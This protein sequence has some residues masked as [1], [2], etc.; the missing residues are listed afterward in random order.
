MTIDVLDN[1]LIL[2]DR[3]NVIRDVVEKYSEDKFYI[4]FSGG[5]DSTVLHYLFDE[6]LQNNKIPRVFC[7]TGIE[8][9]DI[10]AFVQELAKNDDRFIILKPSHNVKATLEKYGYPFKS[11]EHSNILA[12]YQNSG[13]T[14]SVDK[15]LSGIRIK[16]EQEIETSFKC[17]KILTYQFSDDFKIKVSDK[18][19]KKLKKEPFKSY[20]KQSG[21]NICI[22]GMRKSEGGYRNNINCIVYGKDKRMKKFHP[23]SKVNDEW[24]D[25]Y[26]QKRGI[27]LCKLYYP[28]FNFK[29]TGCKGCPFSLNLQEQLEVMARLLP[30]ERK[31]CEMIWKPIYTEYRRLGYRLAENEQIKF[32]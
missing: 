25:W 17:P 24:E 28:L 12:V 13:K 16:D 18:C 27:Q 8:Y 14:K 32:F 26:I 6:A 11:K 29:R 19:C 31:Q 2:F 10:K 5:K 1:E 15:Y 4:S 21:R 30:N 7:D 9:N 20:E 22:T 23:L 3:L